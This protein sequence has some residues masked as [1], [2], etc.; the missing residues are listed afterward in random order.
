VDKRGELLFT[1]FDG[2]VIECD[3]F[4]FMFEANGVVFAGG[5]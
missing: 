3:Q 1:I 2:L 4:G 5:A